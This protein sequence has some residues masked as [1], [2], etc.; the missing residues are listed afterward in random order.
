LGKNRVLVNG[1]RIDPGETVWITSGSAVRI[2]NYLLYFFTP[3]GVIGVRKTIQIRDDIAPIAAKK[4]RTSFDVSTARPA[5]M[6]SGAG[7]GM[8]EEDPKNEVVAATSS[9]LSRAAKTLQNEIEA[10]ST[11]KLLAEMK[12]AQDEDIWDRRHQLIGSTLS[13]RAVLAAAQDTE[14]YQAD[15]GHVSR[16]AIMDWIAASSIFGRW[17]EHMLSKLEP[18][19]YQASITKA[20]IKAGYTR[21][22]SSGRYIKWIVPAP[23]FKSGDSM[24]S[25]SSGAN[26]ANLQEHAINEDASKPSHSNESDAERSDEVSSK[27]EDEGRSDGKNDED[28]NIIDG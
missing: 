28:D 8:V 2:A 5:V 1:A 9:N 6:G 17:V 10:L 11:T 27:G 25:T 21:T 15:G 24:S 4:R 13:Y 12:I 23:S 14:W 20:M 18:K 3:T 22:S 19:S 7:E 26:N 16:S